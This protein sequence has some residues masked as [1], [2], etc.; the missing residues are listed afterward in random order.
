[1][2]RKNPRTARTPANI[3]MT[4][5][6]K[7][8]PSVREGFPVGGGEVSRNKRKSRSAN[9]AN[10]AIPKSKLSSIVPPSI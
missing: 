2:S 10:P 4:A 3:P 1:M 7:G 8:N 5:F 6:A 9:N